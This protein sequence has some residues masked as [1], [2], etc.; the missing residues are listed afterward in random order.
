[1]Q[2]IWKKDAKVRT[3]ISEATVVIREVRTK[4]GHNT[5]SHFSAAANKGF[6]KEHGVFSL[7]ARIRASAHQAAMM[8]KTSTSAA[9]LKGELNL[10][11]QAFPVAVLRS[12]FSSFPSFILFQSVSLRFAAATDTSAGELQWLFLMLA[13]EPRIQEKIQKEIEDTIGKCFFFFV[14]LLKNTQLKNA[15]VRTLHAVT[16]LQRRGQAQR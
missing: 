6:T 5:A 13:K 2:Q 12:R 9:V 15:S 16:L 10:L 4:Q 1:M 8:N 3:W 7:L 11:T 14:R